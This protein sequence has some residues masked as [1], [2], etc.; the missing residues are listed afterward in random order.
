VAQP[1]DR[2][3]GSCGEPNDPVRKFCRRCGASL[4][5]ARIVEARRLPWW[6]RLLGGEKKP[7]QYTAGERTEAMAPGATSG[8]G[9]LG[10][11]IRGALKGMGVVRMLLGL[12]VAIGIF[13]YVGV[14]SVQ[15]AVNGVFSGGIEGVV[16]NIR[17]LIAPTLEIERPIAVKASS[18]VTG[19]EAARLFDTFANTDW[20]GTDKAPEITVTF[21]EPVDLGAVIVHLGNAEAFVDTRR[22]AKL[23]LVFSDG[24]T[25]TITPE[26]VHDPQT[27][28]LSASKTTS[29]TIRIIATNGDEATPISISE[30]EFF[31]K[32]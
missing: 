7:K 3:C 12:V 24:T 1:G 29:V 4:L 6:K 10:G 8:G 28:E 15:S 18:E 17:R 13:G 31:K 11:M 22:P 19:H 20:Q 16:D 23:E 27:F 32:A 26:D 14:P 9:G 2:I 30:L 5:E 21:E 25:K